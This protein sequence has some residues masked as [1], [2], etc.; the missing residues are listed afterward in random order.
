[1]RTAHYRAVPPKSAVGGQFRSSAIYFNRRWSIEGEIRKRR[2]RG[3]RRRRRREK[4][5]VRYS[6]PVPQC[7]PS[8]TGRPRDSSPVSEES[9][10]GAGRRIEVTL[11][12]KQAT[13]IF[14]MLVGLTKVCNTDEYRPYRALVK[15]DFDHRCPLSDDVSRGRRDK[16]EEG[17]EKGEPGDPMLLSLDNPDPSPTGRR[18]LD[19]DSWG[20]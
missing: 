14:T 7:G 10:T 13:T 20:E 11:V 2:R 8:P 15:V 9:P 12:P 3:R 5:L 6:S 1:M 16:E 17:E 4:Y 19:E 18:S